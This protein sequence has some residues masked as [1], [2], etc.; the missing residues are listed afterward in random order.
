MTG[1][2][3]DQSPSN[4]ILSERRENSTG[5]PHSD[6]SETTVSSFVNLPRPLRREE[7]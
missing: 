2:R 1:V 5:A 7:I 6:F 3:Q 4:P